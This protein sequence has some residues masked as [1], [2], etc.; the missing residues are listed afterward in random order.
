M[1]HDNFVA[2]VP[3]SIELSTAGAAPLAGISAIAAIGALHLSE[4][5]TVLI[6]GATGGVGSI[7]SQVAAQ[8]GVTVLARHSLRTRITCAASASQRSSTA[9]QMWRLPYGGRTLTA[10]TPYST[11]FLHP[12]AL[13]AYA[14]ILKA[15][16]RAASTNGAAGEGPGSRQHHGQPDD[17]KS[18][19]PC[20][21]AGGQHNHD[22]DPGKLP[23]RRR[24][25]RTTGTR[26]SP[27]ARES[28]SRSPS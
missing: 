1:P 6:V 21:A 27:H 23:N 3:A 19:A 9:M 11:S 4:G 16:G 2:P 14:A 5:D 13:D 8:A 22:P 25:Q 20:P 28:P 15:G 7:A 10:L 12:R 26:D 18:G 24:R 17:G